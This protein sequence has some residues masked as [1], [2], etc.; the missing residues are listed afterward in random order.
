MFDRFSRSVNLLMSLHDQLKPI[1]GLAII[2]TGFGAQAACPERSLVVVEHRQ[3]G[4][5]CMVAA[6]LTAISARHKPPPFKAV[7]R[8]IPVWPDG[9]HGYD[10][11]MELEHRGWQGFSFI[12][13]PEAAARLV[14]SGFSPVVLLKSKPGRHAVA[15]TGVRRT[16]GADGECGAMLN[17]LQILDPRT[18]QKSWISA[19]N[20]KALQSEGHMFVFFRETEKRELVNHGFPLKI[21]EQM[22]RSFRVETLLRRAQKHER[23][24]LQMLR[25]IGMALELDACHQVARARYQKVSAALSLPPGSVPACKPHKKPSD[26]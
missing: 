25:L 15:V 14:E 2:C 22:D 16:S 4:P 13:P 20:F 18:A 26:S 12:A 11:M 21:A 6:A 17:A 5:T 19:Q 9:V 8:N 10:L 1:L 23:A 24:N 3:S 7:A